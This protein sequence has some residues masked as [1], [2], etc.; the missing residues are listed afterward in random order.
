MFDEFLKGCP[1]N[2]KI[3]PSKKRVKRNVAAVRSL[4][5]KEENSM[6]V[7][8]LKLK[9][10]IVV[11]AVIAGLSVI[12]G[13]ASIGIIRRGGFSFDRGHMPG[14][15]F[16]VMFMENADEAPKTIERLC[17]DNNLPSKY[18]LRDEY[19]LLDNEQYVM[20]YM[21]YEAGAM[22]TIIQAVKRSF[23]N[24]SLREDVHTP[25]E[26]KGHNGFTIV[27]TDERPNGV[28]V[29]NQ[30]VWDCG[31]YIHSVVGSNISMEDV[32]SIVD[33]MTEKQ[34]TPNDAEITT[35]P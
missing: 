8:K 21:D 6:A 11:I 31:E 23:T 20:R 4:I 22:L 14:V 24:V 16:Y 27:H 26:I 3:K 34:A 35:D 30:V 29:D 19:Y 5:E 25:V 10:L 17:Y 12:T 2:D 7:H 13:A 28:F 33:G 18:E 9:P 32:M 1:M 15:D